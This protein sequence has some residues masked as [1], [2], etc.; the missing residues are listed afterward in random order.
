M[1]SMRGREKSTSICMSLVKYI[2]ILYT[3]HINTEG[4]NILFF[5]YAYTT[6]TRK[7]TTLRD[8]YIAYISV[9]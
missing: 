3:S 9:L 8:V 2:I 4:Q 1:E 5:Y 7:T 6:K